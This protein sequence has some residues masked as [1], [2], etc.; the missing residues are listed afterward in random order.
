MRIALA[1][2]LLFPVAFFSGT[3]SAHEPVLQKL[4]A[5][6]DDRDG[7]RWEK[8]C[9]E[10]AGGGERVGL[11]AE[12][13]VGMYR[14]RHGTRESKDRASWGLALLG[15]HA[16]PAL[17]DLLDQPDADDVMSL[18][19]T[20]ARSDGPGAVAPAIPAFVNLALDEDRAGSWQALEAVSAVG[21]FNPRATLGLLPLL[22]S[23]DAGTRR[24]AAWALLNSLGP[25]FEPALK[26]LKRVDLASRLVGAAEKGD[27]PGALAALAEGAR[28][29]DS[30]LRGG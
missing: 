19:L 9:K 30:D 12:W 15:R 21:I 23:P 20:I 24:Q 2:L 11:A 17:A 1:T 18:M 4:Q 7:E 27:V 14:D 3:A 13:L 25:G 10:V 6:F 26:T 8:T 16:V 22:D 29:D 5:Q 28:I